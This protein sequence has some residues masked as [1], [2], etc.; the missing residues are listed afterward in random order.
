MRQKHAEAPS[1]QWIQ[2]RV[3]LTGSLFAVCTT[4][5]TLPGLCKPPFDRRAHHGL[6]PTALKALTTTGL[7]TAS[8]HGMSGGDAGNTAAAVSASVQL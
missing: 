2:V 8:Q 3:T 4:I 6:A 7:L 5:F 1:L